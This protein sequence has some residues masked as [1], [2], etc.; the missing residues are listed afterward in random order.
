M[1]APARWAAG[2]ASSLAATWRR[3][4]IP[5]LIGINSHWQ[6]QESGATSREIHREIPNPGKLEIARKTPRGIRARQ[7]DFPVF[8]HSDKS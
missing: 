7:P 5:G 2:M 3:A 6:L 8:C 1:P 4:A